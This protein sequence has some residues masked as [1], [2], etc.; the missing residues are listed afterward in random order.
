MSL[1]AYLAPITELD[2]VNEMLANIGASPV[3]SI[4]TATSVDAAMAVSCLRAMSRNT[5][6]RG[7]HFNEEKGV[8]LTPNENNEIVLPANTLRVH[9]VLSSEGLDLVH[10]GT[11]L[12]NRTTQSFTITSP[13]TVDYVLMLPF[14]EIPE[15]ARTY[16]YIAAARQFADRALSGSQTVHAYSSQDEA[17]AL[18]NL[19]NTDTQTGGYNI[20]NGS[21]VTA[22]VLSRYGR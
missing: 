5:Q 21:A 9:T 15:A 13:V 19:K 7:W 17:R 8:V 12:Y 11:R 10:R 18:A 2:A 14:E 1:P 16:I 6:S 20:L 22:R 4:V 3:S